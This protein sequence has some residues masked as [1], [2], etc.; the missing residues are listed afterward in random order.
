MFVLLS[1]GNFQIINSI[2]L[3]SVNALRGEIV[4]CRGDE[5]SFQATT[6]VDRTMV[7]SLRCYKLVFTDHLTLCLKCGAESSLVDPDQVVVRI[8]PSK[9]SRHDREENFILSLI[10]I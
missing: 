1:D 3:Q 8:H 6:P 7:R 2:V 4:T 5:T 9:I 10:H